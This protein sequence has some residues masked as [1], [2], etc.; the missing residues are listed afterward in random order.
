[1]LLYRWSYTYSSSMEQGIVDGSSPDTSG[2]LIQR[3][4]YSTPWQYR[5][6]QVRSDVSQ[7]NRPP[8]RL[9]GKTPKL[10]RNL[11]VFER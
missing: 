11:R 5:R 2:Q 9:E 7:L 4:N 10:P 6:R 3:C 8:S 1:M